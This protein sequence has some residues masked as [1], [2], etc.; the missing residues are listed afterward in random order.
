MHHS[1]IHVSWLWFIRAV[2]TKVDKPVQGLRAFG[3]F[4]NVQQTLRDASTLTKAVA[5]T[6]SNFLHG[7]SLN[8]RWQVATGLIEVRQTYFST[9][10]G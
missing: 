8:T 3:R 5:K 2:A 6:S 10:T 1:D 7:G 9:W 4:V